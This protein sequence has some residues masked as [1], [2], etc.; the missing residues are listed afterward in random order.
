MKCRVRDV[1]I[2]YKI[3]GEGRPILFLHGFGLDHRSMTGFMESAFNKRKGWKRIYLDLPGMGMSTTNPCVTN[4]DQMLDIIL[5]F[6]DS[7]MPDQHFVL[8]GYSYGGYLARGLVRNRPSSIDGLFLLCPVIVAEPAKRA[9]P[10]H[11]PLVRDESFLST[12]EQEKKEAFESVA[13]VQ[14]QHTWERTQAEIVAGCELADQAFIS[15]LAGNAY[16]FSFDVDSLPSPFE[17]PTLIVTGKQDSVVGSQDAWSILK[18]YPRGTFVA[19]D[20]AGH[21]LQIEQEHLLDAL[22]AEWFERVEE[23]LG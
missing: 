21:N 19:L 23:S 7:V 15:K 5:E 14:T 16:S 6:I 20:R 2:H 4:S 22:V 11:T 9:L 1:D 8:V 12:I 17:P 13:V 18:N 10:L 3:F